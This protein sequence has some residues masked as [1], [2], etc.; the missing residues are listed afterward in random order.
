VSRCGSRARSASCRSIPGR[1]SSSAC[2]PGI[3]ITGAILAARETSAIHAGTGHA[4]AFV[5]SYHVGLYVSAAVMAI[6][7]LVAVLLRRRSAP[8]RVI[9]EAA[10]PNPPST[11]STAPV[12]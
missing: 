2:A 12:M 10:S 8:Q 4:A 7:A 3:A 11:L 1:S 9:A 5:D 6:G